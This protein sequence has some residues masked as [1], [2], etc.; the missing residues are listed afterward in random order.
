M[1]KAQKLAEPAT[2][3]AL[4]VSLIP[5]AQNVIQSIIIEALEIQ[6]SVFVMKGS[7]IVEVRHVHHAIQAAELAPIRNKLVAYLV[8]LHPIEFLVEANVPVIQTFTKRLRNFAPHVILHYIV[9]L[10]LTLQHVPLVI[11]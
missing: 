5:S 11:L 4:N 8:I 1:K 6:D 7:L 9:L 3:P 10:V 2:I